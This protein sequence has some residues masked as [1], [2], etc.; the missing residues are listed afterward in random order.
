MGIPEFV[1]RPGAHRTCT[2]T[3]KNTA[4]KDGNSKQWSS[5]EVFFTIVV[6]RSKS[7]I[8]ELV[9]TGSVSVAL[10]VLK[11]RKFLLISDFATDFA[12]TG[13]MYIPAFSIW[14]YSDMGK[15]CIIS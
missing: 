3:G 15:K 5:R 4:D 9:L 14:T 2:N 6:T 8:R 12:T 10:P 1:S 7:G 13:R 11:N